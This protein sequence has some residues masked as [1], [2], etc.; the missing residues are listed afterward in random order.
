[1]IFVDSNIPMYLVGASHPNKASALELLDRLTRERRRLVTSAE[2]Y[3]EIIHRFCAIHRREGIRVAF[4][5]MDALSDQVFSIDR[6]DLNEAHRVAL[7]Y[8]ALSARDALHVALMTRH[9][10]KE[11]LS[12]DRGF[13]QV[14]GISRIGH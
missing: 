9:R 14:A 6:E 4:E 12:F 8:P 7:T 5:A 11:I 13:D 3:Q 2:A 1:M 10:I